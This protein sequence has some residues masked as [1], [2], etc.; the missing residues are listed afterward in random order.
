MTASEVIRQAIRFGEDNAIQS[1]D[2]ERLT[3]SS[4]RDVKKCIEALRR[5]GVVICSSSKGYF[6]P[7]SKAE[8]RKF[9]HQEATRAHSINVTL[10][11]AEALYER[12]G[13]DNE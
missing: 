12:W 5:S 2:L 1:R 4:P 3:D 6:Y 9:I 11:S 10:R 13:G 8:L 7:D